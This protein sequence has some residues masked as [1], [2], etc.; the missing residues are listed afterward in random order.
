MMIYL[1][2]QHPQVEAKIRE[3]IDCFMKKDDYSF[4]NLKNFKYIDMVQKE[5]TRIYGPAIALF[6][7]KAIKDNILGGIP[8]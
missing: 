7:R 5:T 3:E 6:V 4:E 1:I 8:I 2:A